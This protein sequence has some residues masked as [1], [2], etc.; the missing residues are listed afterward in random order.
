MEKQKGIWIRALLAL[1]FMVVVTGVLLLVA[2]AVVYR[3]DLS[4]ATARILI[5]AIY[6]VVGLAGGFFMG[7]MMKVRKF[8]WGIVAGLLYFCCLML[9]SLMVNGGTV[10][11]VV[12][13]LITFVLIEASAM[14]GGMVS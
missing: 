6:A 13:M 11:D 7:K 4:S 12:Q 9:V 14:I 5:T 8:L 1:A 3:M 2:A 10:E